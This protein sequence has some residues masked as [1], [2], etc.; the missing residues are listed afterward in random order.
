LELLTRRL[1]REPGLEHI[2]PTTVRRFFVEAGLSWQADRSFCTSTD[3]KLAEKRAHRG[4]LCHA[5]RPH[6]PT[7]G[8]VFRRTRSAPAH[9]TA[10]TQLAAARSTTA[11]ALDLSSQPGTRQLLALLHPRDGHVLSVLRPNRRTE[12]VLALLLPALD[13]ELASLPHTGKLYVILDNLNI[14]QLAK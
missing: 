1:R 4:S 13:D 12:T 11:A 8:G 7:S 3:P 10:R 5:E 14:H 9:P 6:Q 2:D